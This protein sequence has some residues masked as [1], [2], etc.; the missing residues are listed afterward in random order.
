MSVEIT[1]IDYDLDS[2]I[3]TEK[4]KRSNPS[5]VKFRKKNISAGRTRS[6]YTVQIDK[7]EFFNEIM[8]SLEKDDLTPR[9]AELFII[10]G[11]N[12]IK[13]KQKDYKSKDDM[14]DCLQEGYLA[15]FSRWRGFN[16]EFSENAFAYYTEIFKRAIAKGFN[17]ITNRKKSK[18]CAG[19]IS[20][21]R[22]N[23]GEGLFSF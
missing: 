17:E 13:K 10:L 16:P 3:K 18:E 19:F 23:E 20:I 11:K 4:P 2:K 14:Y 21:E 1:D 6:P 12:I 22:G 9:A 7:K 15:L 8:K 5:T